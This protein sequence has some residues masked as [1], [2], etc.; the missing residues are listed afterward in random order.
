ME[1]FNELLISLVKL[2]PIVGL[3]IFALW[4]MHKENKKIKETNEE[5]NK[6][7]REESVKNVKILESVSNTLERIVDDNHSNYDRLKE[8]I[9]LKF[10]EKK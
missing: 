8:F 5:L 4:Y 1:L 7:I 2:S 6:F 9:T 3:L 10:N